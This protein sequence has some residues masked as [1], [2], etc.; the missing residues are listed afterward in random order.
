[1]S[2]GD[3]QIV[4]TERCFKQGL[5]LAKDSI[6]FL[7][8]VLVV[9]TRFYAHI[10]VKTLLTERHGPIMDQFNAAYHGDLGDSLF[11]NTFYPMSKDHRKEVA[12]IMKPYATNRRIMTR[13]YV[14]SIVHINIIVDDDG[15]TRLQVR[16][17]SMPE[18]ITKYPDS[19]RPPTLSSRTGSDTVLS[20]LYHTCNKLQQELNDMSFNLSRYRSNVLE[21]YYD[22]EDCDEYSN[23]DENISPKTDT[24]ASYCMMDQ[25]N[26]MKIQLVFVKLASVLRFIEGMECNILEMGVKFRGQ[27]DDP[28]HLNPFRSAVDWFRG[29]TR[30]KFIPFEVSRKRKQ[31]GDDNDYMQLQSSQREYDIFDEHT[32]LKNAHLPTLT[33]EDYE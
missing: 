17:N 8:Q 18:I 3:Y 14:Q 7:D 31:I 16:Y 22:N 1:M 15:S 13:K 23:G 4:L 9:L 2:E 32:T 20:N 29:Q 28:N 5:E 30:V 6:N 33:N 24:L 25:I 11:G 27:R 19:F 21:Y 26:L 10:P 12:T